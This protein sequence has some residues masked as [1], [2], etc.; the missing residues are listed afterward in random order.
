MARSRHDQR[1]RRGAGRKPTDGTMRLSR[2]DLAQLDDAY[3]A[4]L[5]EASLRAL[6]VK[7]LADFKEAHERLA[8]NPSNSSRPPSRCVPWETAQ[9][10]QDGN[11]AER[12]EGPEA[13][14]VQEGAPPEPS[15]ELQGRRRVG[16]HVHGRLQLLF[17]G[18]NTVASLKRAAAVAD[19]RRLNDLSVAVMP[20]PHGDELH[21]RAEARAIDEGGSLSQRTQ[22]QIPNPA[23]SATHSHFRTQA[24]HATHQ[25]IDIE[26]NPT[27]V[28]NWRSPHPSEKRAEK[29]TKSA[30][31]RRGRSPAVPVNPFETTCFSGGPI[32][33]EKF[34]AG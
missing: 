28:L 11:A 17:C 26:G 33:R 30:V 7:L 19:P 21:V 34:E 8:Q 3:L 6:S 31:E 10:D 16:S 9:G 14:D 4:G 15:A 12:D 5:E 27:W 22:A 18:S 2:H 25:A 23:P 13:G 20:R 29:R 1:R 24:E 32:S